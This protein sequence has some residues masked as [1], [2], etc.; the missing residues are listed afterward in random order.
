ME[1]RR[2]GRKI[3][4]NDRCLKRSRVLWLI[5]VAALAA[6]IAVFVVVAPTPLFP[7]KGYGKDLPPAKLLD[8]FSSYSTA[9]LQVKDSR[10]QNRIVTAKVGNDVEVWSG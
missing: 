2:A 1:V 3:G 4:R 8:G 7:P 9:G 5:L 10:D 6:A